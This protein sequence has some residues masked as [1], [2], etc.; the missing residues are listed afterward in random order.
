MIHLLLVNEIRLMC[1]VLNAALEDEPDIK[2]VACATSVEEALDKNQEIGSEGVLEGSIIKADQHTKEPE[3]N[4]KKKGPKK[5]NLDV[6]TDIV[7]PVSQTPQSLN[8]HVVPSIDFQIS[9]LLASVKTA[10]K[11]PFDVLTTCLE[12]PLRAPKSLVSSILTGLASK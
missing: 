7:A 5:I 9:Q 8:S 6:A 1:N 2:V 11:T 3:Q 10:Y 12:R 4:V